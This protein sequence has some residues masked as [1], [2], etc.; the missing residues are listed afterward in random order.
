MEVYLREYY[1]THVNN[2]EDTEDD[3]QHDEDSNDP[4]LSQP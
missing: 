3:Q 2:K 1:R 4:E